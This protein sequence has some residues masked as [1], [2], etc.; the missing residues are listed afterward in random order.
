M[1]PNS[2]VLFTPHAADGLKRG[3]DTLARTLAA[4][5]G[6]GQGVVLNA[7]EAG[8]TPELLEDAATIARRV[9]QLPDRVEDVGAMLLRNLVWRMRTQAGDGSALTAVLAGAIL[10]ETHR[11]AAA[12]ANKMLLREGIQMG[13]KAAMA[14]LAQMSRPVE[15]EIDLIHFA[16]TVT[17]HQEIGRLL[18]EIYDILGADAHITVEDYVAPYFERDYLEG[19][20][21]K[22]KLASPYLMTDQARGRALQFPCH[23]VLYAGEVST[24]EDIAAVLT[25]AASAEVKKLALFVH[26]ISGAALNT[27]VMNHHQSKMSIIAAALRETASKRRFDFEDLATLTGATVISPEK[28]QTLTG[29]QITDMGTAKR[30]EADAEEVI[31]VG[32]GRQN[33]SIRTQ[34]ERLRQRLHQLE[35][36]DETR[37]ETRMRLARLS[38]NIATLKIGA[39]TAVERKRLHQRAEKGI[40]AVP[41]ALSDGLVPGGGV[42]LLNS[43]PAVK[44]VQAEGEVRWGVEAFARALKAPFYQIV[45]NA[46]ILEPGVALADAQ[47]QGSNFGYNALT[48][49]IVD[50]TEAGI[51]DAAAVLQQAIRTAASGAAM[52]LTIDTI[53]LK[54][55]PQTSYTP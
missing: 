49:E 47:R 44:R 4:T 54:K 10:D 35:P 21:W 50:M 19:G 42:A 51:W 53:V 43:I 26:D 37:S 11:L 36:E 20:R 5:L 29:I 32:D 7:A 55:R 6:P 23:V 27:V 38:G 30:V 41:L 31:V 16:Q 39:L 18:G 2:H 33:Q 13:A 22:G 46:N 28:G 3:F 9:I 34:I 45:G 24:A 17:G 14:A 12:G 48:A 25:L 15:D 52:A 8:N 40:R 1:M